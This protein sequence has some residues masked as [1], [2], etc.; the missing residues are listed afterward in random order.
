MRVSD[1]EFKL[2]EM[3]VA[4]GDLEVVNTHGQDIFDIY[5]DIDPTHVD[6]QVI[7]LKFD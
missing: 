2:H 4:Q 6:G 5:S 3:R 1:L 7:V